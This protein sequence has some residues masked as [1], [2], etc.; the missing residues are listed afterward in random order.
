MNI[1]V[2]ALAFDDMGAAISGCTATSSSAHV[3]MCCCAGQRSSK[4]FSH[5]KH[6]M[7]KV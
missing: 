1:Y 7:N 5:R 2:A 3:H 4:R 6:S